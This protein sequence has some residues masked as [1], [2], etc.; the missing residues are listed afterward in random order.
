MENQ[1]K[2]SSKC[3]GKVICEIPIKMMSLNDYV[4]LCRGNYFK[5]N[6]EVQNLEQE[7]GLYISR[8]PHFSKPIKIDFHWIE[9]NRRRD[10]DNIC[11]A[12]KFILDS[13]VKHGKMLDDNRKCVCDFHDS[14]YI[15][16]NK[17]FKV[18]LEITEVEHGTETIW[19]D[20]ILG[21]KSRG[22]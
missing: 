11:F 5:A 15:S 9:G 12:K 3:S 7:I 6:N 22:S 18:I 1:Q 8:L 20:S 16:K 17:E 14:F 2:I 13:M 10:F 19:D 4:K 21:D